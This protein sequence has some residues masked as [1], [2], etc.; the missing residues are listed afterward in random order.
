MIGCRTPAGILKHHPVT[1]IIGRKYRCRIDF[2][3]IGNCTR[4]PSFAADPYGGGSHVNI[5]QI[6]HVVVIRNDPVL[7]PVQVI[8]PG[9]VINPQP[10][11]I[12][13]ILNGS[14]QFRSGICPVGLI[15]RKEVLFKN[16][17]IIVIQH[18]DV[19]M[20]SAA[21]GIHGASG[22]AEKT[23]LAD[24]PVSQFRVAGPNDH[25][26]HVQKRSG[27]DVCYPG[28]NDNKLRLH[29]G[30]ECTV[31]DCAQRLRKDDFLQACARNET[32][33]PDAR[34]G[35]GPVH[36]GQAFAPLECIIFDG[37]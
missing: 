31:P 1:V 8:R 2:K 7:I 15:H 3:C 18:A 28:R 5:V 34:K 35:V 19:E 12:V 16:Q 25:E 36:F 4:T 22:M 11:V 23:A 26:R 9:P 29:A 6:R 17:L 14:R 32:S 20:G 21:N 27:T 10:G 33:F 30:A 24:C 13:R 37:G